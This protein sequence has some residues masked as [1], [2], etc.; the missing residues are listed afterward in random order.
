MY[1]LLTQALGGLQ[2]ATAGAIDDS[3]TPLI[4]HVCHTDDLVS[5]DVTSTENLEADGRPLSDHVGTLV[6]LGASS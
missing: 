1:D 5:L 3:A 2:I 4:D 6:Q